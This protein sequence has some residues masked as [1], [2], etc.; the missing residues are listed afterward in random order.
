LKEKMTVEKKAELQKRFERIAAENERIRQVWYAAADGLF[1]QEPISPDYFCYCLN[2]LIEDD[3][4]LVNHT[5]S[6]C[7]SVT[8]QIVRTKPGTW[9]G[10]PSGAIGWAPGAALGAAAASPGKLVV[11]VMTDGGFIWGCPTSTFWTSAQYQFPFLAVIFNNRGYGAIRD[12]QQEMLGVNRPSE[13]FIFESALDFMPDYAAIVRGVGAFGRRVDKS[14]DVLPA[15]R[16]AIAAVRAGQ[17]AVL[18]VHLA[19]ER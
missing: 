13:K 15:L 17:P 5:L 7:A 16:E 1:G 9:F 4:I 14:E 18:D 19:R 2:R 11:S 10:C 12:V 3:A 6:H 8:E